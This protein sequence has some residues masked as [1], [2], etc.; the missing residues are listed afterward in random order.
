[1]KTN[2]IASGKEANFKQKSVSADV[3]ASITA[4][5]D[6]VGDTGVKGAGGVP[7]PHTVRAGGTSSV[8]VNNYRP[9]EN[10]A[11]DSN[12]KVYKTT[13]KS[14]QLQLG[15]GSAK[16]SSSGSGASTSPGLVR[17]GSATKDTGAASS[18]GG[19]G[20]A[21]NNLN[22]SVGGSAK[23]NNVVATL[24]NKK[25]NNTSNKDDAVIR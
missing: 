23:E 15:N 11:N 10:A 7:R 18:G 20:A 8:N 13:A 21:K 17:N 24:T 25:S 12:A 19:G 1:V 2:D 3:L 6:D 14:L 16:N 4:T 22:A 5:M 9:E